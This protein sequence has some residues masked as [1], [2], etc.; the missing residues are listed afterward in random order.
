MQR[1]VSVDNFNFERLAQTIHTPGAE[2]TPRSDVIGKHLQ[3]RHHG[4]GM[5]RCVYLVK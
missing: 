3:D 5:Q 4:L 2:V 1:E